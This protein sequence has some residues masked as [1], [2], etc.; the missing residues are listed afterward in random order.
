MCV[1]LG[2]LV[3]CGC[4]RRVAARAAAAW[5]SPNPHTHAL[6]HPPPQKNTNKKD[7]A[8]AKFLVAAAIEPF[9]SFGGVRLEDNV[10]ITADG[11]HS[12]T[13]VPRSVAD[14]EAVMAGKLEWK[15]EDRSLG[16]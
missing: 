5:A 14:I 11:S 1:R 8:R 10:L 7:P 3:V 12:F 13:H 4:G 9:Y 2:V 15:V 16:A 6:P